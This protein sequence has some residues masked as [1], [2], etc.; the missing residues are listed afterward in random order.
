MYISNKRYILLFLTTVTLILTSCKK[1]Y[2]E[3][4]P[5][6]VIV[7]KTTQDYEALLN[8]TKVDPSEAARFLGDEVGAQRDYFSGASIYRQRLFKYV[9]DALQ[10]DDFP[11]MG[12]LQSNYVFNKIINEIGASTGGTE[13]QKAQILAE[14][15]VGRAVCHLL[16]LNDFGKPYNKTTAAA[17]LG[18]PIITSADVIKTDYKRATV[19]E[20]YD[21]IIKDITEALPN[22]SK[23][24]SSPLKISKAA[25]EGILARVYLYIHDY[26][27]SSDHLDKAF[28]ALTG[29][30]R[31]V[32][33]YDYNE[34]LSPDGSWQ[35]SDPQAFG[36]AGM[37]FE[38]N[39]GSEESVLTM[40]MPTL[41]LSSANSFVF[42]PETAALYDPSDYRLQIYSDTEIF[43]TVIFKNGMRRYPRFGAEVGISLPDMYLMRAELKARANDLGGAIADVQLL[44][45]N[46]MPESEVAVP[47][48]V[49]GNQQSLVRFILEERIRE[50]ALKGMRWYDMRRLWNDPLYGNTINKT[51]KI[52]S[53]S[54]AEVETYPLTPDRLVLKFGKKLVSQHPL[55]IDND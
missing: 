19:Q 22:L 33:L 50:F 38:S 28:S 11:E 45:A 23:P 42:N 2:L 46:R 36:P 18:V 4:E 15:K 3:V 24:F 31:P 53:A 30:T 26:A 55:L 14:A 20:V 51:H 44:R 47:A 6:D 32:G 40:Y 5:K 39:G 10:P 37:P 16:F 48:L 54:G 25:A 43:G 49:A 34:T 41:T 13:Q 17:D 12:Y 35:P 52:Y 27:A 7:A 21:F 29:A 8:T 9:G 1:D